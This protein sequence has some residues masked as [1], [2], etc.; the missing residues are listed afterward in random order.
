M[1]AQSRN[2]KNIETRNQKLARWGEDLA[3][4][5][6]KEKGF[7][8]IAVN[9]RTPYGEVDLIVSNDAGFHFVEVKTRS[10]Q[11]FGQPEA[12]INTRKMNHIKQSAAWY[13]QTHPE[14]EQ[15]WQ[16]DVIAILVD[17]KNWNAH[18][19]EWFENVSS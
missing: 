6:M 9:T 3:G 5:F 14:V 17:P 10:S 19:V 12:A 13:I 16:I 2:I 15:N 8:I 18:Q 11:V 7:R 4:Y 1:N